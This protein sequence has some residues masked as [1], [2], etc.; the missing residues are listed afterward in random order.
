MS[1]FTLKLIACIAMLIDHITALF[2][3]DI[4][5]YM[6]GRGIG[7][8]AFP[9]FCFLI[10]EGFFHT[11][12]VKKYLIRLGIFAL[13]SEFAYDFAFWDAL[14]MRS[15][16]TQQNVFFTLFIGLLTITV[17]DYFVKKYRD[18]PFIFNTYAVIAIVIGGAV[19]VLL[20][21]DYSFYG[22]LIILVFYIF[23]WNKNR[24]LIA[25]FLLSGFLFSGIQLLAVFA[26]P[27]LWL[28]NGK[29]GP[30]VKCA[31]YAFYPVH[32]LILGLIARYGGM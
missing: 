11:S 6:I 29:K 2:V 10:V 16:F 13:I 1:S 30:S 9:I 14:H 12:N 23:H 15:I 8:I 17:Y 24:M 27:F 19:A 20:K 26:L 3:T 18:Q 22:V 32:I 7:R 31:F 5:A 28:Y 25:Y 4:T 21:T